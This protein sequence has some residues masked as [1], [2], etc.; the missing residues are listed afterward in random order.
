MRWAL[1]R[2]GPRLFQT[3][4]AVPRHM[5]YAAAGNAAG[6]RGPTPF[7]L[8]SSVL[9]DLVTAGVLPAE[10]RPDAEYS[11]WSSVHGMAVLITQGPLRGM[12]A[13]FIRHL[14]DQL[15]AFITRGL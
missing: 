13:P 2:D 10:R 15:L 11:V 9:D 8:L 7:Q 1:I 5:E 14:T 4:F 6:G 3:A 12:P